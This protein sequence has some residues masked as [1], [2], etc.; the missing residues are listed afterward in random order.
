M[1]NCLLH[2]ATLADGSV[3]KLCVDRGPKTTGQRQTIARMLSDASNHPDAEE[4]HRRAMLL[5]ARISIATVYRTVRL[6]E[7]KGIL[8]RRDFGNGRARYEPT[9][10]GPHHHLIDVETGKVVEFKNSEHERLVR[11]LAEQL[12]FAVVSLQLEVFGKR[13]ETHSKSEQ[14]AATDAA[15]PKRRW[16]RR[17]V[18]WRSGS[19]IT[20]CRA[21]TV[22]LRAVNAS[23]PGLG[24][25]LLVLPTRWIG[26]S[27]CDCCCE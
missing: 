27:A 17:G 2:P 13:L 10:H 3:E 12:G 24:C 8:Q 16:M 15:L 20:S 4:L 5:D 6:F 14:A 26:R 22:P 25:R 9:D 1:T 21:T 19:T 18:W 11:A 23:R 7:E